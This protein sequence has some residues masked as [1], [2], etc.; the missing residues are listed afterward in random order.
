MQFFLW[1]FYFAQMSVF[2][3]EM[4]FALWICDEIGYIG[5]KSGRFSVP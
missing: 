5:T 3:Q 4:H 2:Q 1:I